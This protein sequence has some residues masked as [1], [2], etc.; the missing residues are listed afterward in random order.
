MTHMRLRHVA[1]VNPSSPVFDRLSGN[2]DISFLRMESVWPGKWHE[3][4]EIRRKSD[5]ISGFTRFQDGDILVPKITPTF[6]ASR[7]ILVDGLSSGAGAGTTELHVV[8]PGGH[9]YPRFLLHLMHSH[10]FL[11]VGEAEMYGVAGQK[12]V[13]DDFLRDLEV[14]IP[15]PDEQ[16]RIADFLDAEVNRIEKIVAKR[17]RQLGLASLRRERVIEEAL[18]L[19]DSCEHGKLV[20]L[21]YLVHRVGV[22]IVIT[23]ASWYVEDGGVPAL[24]GVNIRPGEITQSDMI[25]IS[26]EGHALHRKSQLSSGDLVVVRTGQAGV[27]AVVPDDLDGANCIDLVIIRPGGDINSNYIEY[28][29]NSGYVKR[30]VSEYSV[31]SIQSHFNVSAMKDMPIPFI[32]LDKQKQVVEGLDRRVGV[33][34]DFQERV[35]CQVELLEERK[36]ALITAAVT[37][38]IDVTTARGA[39]LS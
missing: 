20:P 15:E 24:R 14:W 38:Q 29:L 13:P 30:H 25:R 35:R 1:Q 19:G 26:S 36:R 23:P 37:G 9:I 27:A 6:E 5:V 11:R 8:R 10:R 2:A 28:I 34:D 22:G 12:R 33:I 18:T 4:S 39:D 32:A 7:S 21:K 16:C 17:R 3:M 31:G